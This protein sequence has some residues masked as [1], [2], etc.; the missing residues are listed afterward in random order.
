MIKLS[1]TKFIAVQAILCSII[2]IF[3]FI[4]ANI[5]GAAIAIVPLIAIAISGCLFGFKS[6][7]FT[8]T[9]FGIISLISH[10]AIPKPISPFFYNPLVSVIPR[11]I[12]GFIPVLSMH[13]LNKIKK[14]PALVKFSI[15][16]FLTAFMN[17]VLVMGSIFLFYFGQKFGNEVVTVV[18][19]EWLVTIILAN[20]IIEWIICAMI[21]PPL[22][23]IIKKIVR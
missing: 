16:G 17:T 15:S 10:I 12:V 18:G 5:G 8:G 2:L 3:I 13:L 21:V 4:P 14:M 6:S 7:F 23:L 22:C 11:I 20:A 1:K 9:F 19:K